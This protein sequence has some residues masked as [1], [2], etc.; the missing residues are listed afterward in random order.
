MTRTLAHLR[1][2]GGRLLDVV[3]PPQCLACGRIVEDLG[4]LCPECWQVMDFI[5]APQCAACG[6][7]FEYLMEAD[8]LCPQALS[9]RPGARRTRL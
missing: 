9:V 6:R 1:R 5:A 7:P 3:L 2:L 8:T 4:G